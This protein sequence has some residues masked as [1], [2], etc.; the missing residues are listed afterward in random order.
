M[1]KQRERPSRPPP[2]G[3]EEVNIY[4]EQCQSALHQTLREDHTLLW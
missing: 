4:S 1:S 3:G 2:C